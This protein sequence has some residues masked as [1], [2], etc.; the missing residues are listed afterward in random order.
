MGLTLV[1]PDY[2]SWGKILATGGMFACSL[3]AASF[4][5]W[6]VQPLHTCRIIWLRVHVVGIG[7]ERTARRGWLDPAP[8]DSHVPAPRNVTRKPGA[9][10]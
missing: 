2:A 6:T 5:A 10:P 9:R 1:H 4:A 8:H 7:V 3:V